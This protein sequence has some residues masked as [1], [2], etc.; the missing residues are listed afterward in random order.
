MYLFYETKY[1]DSQ[2]GLFALIMSKCLLLV[3]KFPII[4]ASFYSK[5]GGNIFHNF[6]QWWCPSMATAFWL[7]QKE[8]NS[9][10]DCHVH[11]EV[12]AH[13]STRVHTSTSAHTSTR[14][15]TSTRAHISVE[16]RRE[17]P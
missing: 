6:S 1:S 3:L 4:K 5:L 7:T 2:P 17:L 14:A 8:R 15:Q 12:H 10:I 13:T 16:S 11:K 9:K